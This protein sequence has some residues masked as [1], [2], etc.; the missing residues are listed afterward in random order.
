MLALQGLAWGVHSPGLRKRRPWGARAY[1]EVSME[2][3]PGPGHSG[4]GWE[5]EALWARG[6]IRTGNEEKHQ[7]HRLPREVIQSPTLKISR[8]NKKSPE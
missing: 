6:D 8:P 5:N 3:E 2:M 7:G 1:E 4:T